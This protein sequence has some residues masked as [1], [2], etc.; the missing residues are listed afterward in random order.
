[1]V[2]ND[3]STHALEIHCS[4]LPIVE[5]YKYLGVCINENDNYLRTQQEQLKRKEAILKH[6]SVGAVGI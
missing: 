5:E 2:F 3:T 6:R 1:M 4:E